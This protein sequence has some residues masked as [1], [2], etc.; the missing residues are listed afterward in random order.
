[1]EAA[2][3]TCAGRRTHLVTSPHEQRVVVYEGVVAAPLQAARG[4]PL[5]GIHPRNKTRGSTGTEAARAVRAAPGRDCGERR[6]RW[7]APARLRSVFYRLPV[8]TRSSLQLIICDLNV[9]GGEEARTR[10]LP[11]I[12]VAQ[13]SVELRPERK[14]C[15]KQRRQQLSRHLRIPGFCFH[16]KGVIYFLSVKHLST[17]KGA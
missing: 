15:V 9:G 4:G 16:Y 10:T 5:H 13:T 6:L 1:M 17:L 11:H 12:R 3:H 14:I 8:I 2:A 7:S